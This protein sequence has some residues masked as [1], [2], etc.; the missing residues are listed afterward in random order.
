MHRLV[1]KGLMYG[2]LVRIE[3]PDGRF[4]THARLGR[5]QGRRAI[6]FHLDGAE[7]EPALTLDPEPGAPP[8]LDG[9][10]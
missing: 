7:A 3:A 10:D 1:A 8:V 6:R 9:P 2:N 4:V 5:S